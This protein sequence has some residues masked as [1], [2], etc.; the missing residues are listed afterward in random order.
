[1]RVKVNFQNK[2]IYGSTPKFNV[3]MYDQIKRMYFNNPMLSHTFP[4]MFT[5]EVRP[6]SDNVAKCKLR[7]VA[8]LQEGWKYEYRRNWQACI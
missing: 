1:M 7:H 4:F 3:K 6:T 5:E 2:T 8:V